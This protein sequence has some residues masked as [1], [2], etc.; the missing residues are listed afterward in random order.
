MKKTAAIV[1][2]VALAAAIT[3]VPA[4]ADVG[5]GLG[6]K[7]GVSLGISD[8]SGEGDLP[9]R[10][11]RPVFGAF[12]SIDL[13]G[14]LAFQPEL[15]FVTQGGKWV[16]DLEGRNEVIAKLTTI[17]IP[18]LLKLRPARI[19]RLAPVLFAGPAL[20]LILSAKHGYYADGELVEENYYPFT[21]KKTGFDIIFGGGLDVDMDDFKLILDVRYD[22]GLA[23]LL[24]G[25]PGQT[26]KT[27]A[28]MVLAG[29]GF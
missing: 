7:G 10:V 27:S 28:L 6:I 20:D 21:L 15:Y 11:A 22:L 1:L 26:Y 16:Q 19:G 12:V 5:L 18:A 8:Y 2:S 14:L 23:N 3:P 29:I 9:S 24:S 13:G 25:D 4:S 17:H